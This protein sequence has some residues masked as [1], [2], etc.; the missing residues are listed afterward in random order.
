MSNPLSTPSAASSPTPVQMMAE[1][2][3][4][5]MV[6]QQGQRERAALQAQLEAAQQLS[7]ASSSD[8]S[9]QVSAPT[10][11]RPGAQLSGLK[12]PQPDKFKGDIGADCDRWI[13]SLERYY[14]FLGVDASDPRRVS[15]AVLH[16]SDNA[17]LWWENL[18]TQGR[19]AASASWE[20]F[21][22]AL[23]SRFRPVLQAEFARTRLFAVKQAPSESVSSL[24]YRFLRELGPIEQEMHTKDQIHHFRAALKDR[25]IVYKLHETK[26][27][28]LAEAIQ[29]ATN[30]EA[31]FA[32]AGSALS[33]AAPFLR[34]GHSGYGSSLAPRASSSSSSSGSVPMEIS[35]LEQAMFDDGAMVQEPTSSS[36]A[37]L[38][39]P[40][41][42][43]VMKQLVE[44][45]KSFIAVMSS[46]RGANQG[47]P[48]WDPSI[49]KKRGQFVPGLDPALVQNRLRRGLCIKC[50]EKGHMKNE[51]TNGVQV[52]PLKE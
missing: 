21:V 7:S 16:F 15:V 1:I 17:E 14:D 25:R 51:C 46:Q 11:V 52:K 43:E 8:S 30:W 26:P 41:T 47:A 27:S 20:T 3:R 42:T 50:G 49:A 6:E 2:N 35:Q 37:A 5:R 10:G 9:P 45:Q 33:G 22:Q 18:G 24:V 48:R 39:E 13:R 34:T 36:A 19:A 29:A 12:L 32:S 23:L 40:T 31:Q 44:M 4:L 28:S 38:K